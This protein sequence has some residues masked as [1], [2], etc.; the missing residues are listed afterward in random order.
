[1][2]ATRRTIVGSHPHRRTLSMGREAIERALAMARAAGG[3]GAWEV[4]LMAT[5]RR[6]PLHRMH[7][8]TFAPWLAPGL[9][10]RSATELEAMLEG[11]VRP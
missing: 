3:V 6:P 1:M 2:T 9:S 7:A 4:C 5:R 10:L 11:E 8:N